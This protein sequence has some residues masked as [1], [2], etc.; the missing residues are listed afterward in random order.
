VSRSTAASRFLVVLATLALGCEEKKAPPAP[1]PPEVLVVTVAPREVPI[2]KEWVG[3][4]DADINAEIRARVQGIIQTQD[5]TEGSLVKEGQVLFTLEPNTLKATQVE[6]AGSYQRAKAA[7]DQSKVEVNRFKH[8]VEGGAASQMD[9]DHTIALER[10]A[11][12]TLESYGGTVEKTKIDLSYAKVVSPIAGI[13]GIARVKVGNLVGKGEP[14]LLTTVSNVDPIRVAF[15]ITEPEYLNA[16]DAL[17]NPEAIGKAGEGYLD[18][19]LA[20][21]KVYA[22]KGR[23]AVTNR[24]FDPKTG[25]MTLQALFPNPDMLLR[26]GQYGRVRAAVRVVKDALVVPQRAVAEMQ[27]VT[28]IALVGPTDQIEIRPVK[29]GERS[30]SFWIVASGLKPGERVVAEGIQKVRPGMTV[31]PKPFDTSTLKQPDAVSDAPAVS[32]EAAPVKPSG[33]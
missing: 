2:Y 22:H 23:L 19:I 28:Q 4:I 15:P 24:E 1:P 30:G 6:A 12:A 16:A 21:G 7:W 8:L 5:Y 25:T 11:R 13:A 26:P 17:K 20:N 14:T 29:M 33:P 18:L 10:A 9:L 32:P 27:G 31:A 3:T